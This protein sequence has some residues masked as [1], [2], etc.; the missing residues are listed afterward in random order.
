MTAQVKFQ[1]FARDI[2]NGKHDFSSHTFKAML[3]NTAPDASAN[4][5]KADIT[6]IAAGNGYTAGGVSIAAI[7]E[8]LA[9]GTETIKATNKTIT[10]SGGSIGPFRYV[11]FYNDT[12][13][14][15]AKPLVSY[16]D[17]GASL[18]LADGDSVNINFDATNG[19][20]QVA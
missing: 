17:R 9:A 14:T 16:V 12:Q 3:T 4:A 19:L 1:I 11:V 20:L 7:T 15:P 18:T 6:D 8:T 5:V 13:T 2:A 10:A